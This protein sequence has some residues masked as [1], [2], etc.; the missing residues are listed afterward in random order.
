MP[1]QSIIGSAITASA[2]N[3]IQTLLG[4][5]GRSAIYL[6]NTILPNQTLDV[7][8]YI[9]L[10]RLRCLHPNHF[11]KEMLELG[12]DVSAIDAKEFKLCQRINADQIGIRDSTFQTA[13][14]PVEKSI[15][16]SKNLPSIDELIV[17][18]NR[19]QISY[20]LAYWMAK[21]QL[22]G[23]SELATEMLKLRYQIPG[24]SDLVSFAVRDCFTPEIVQ[25]FEYAK[26]LPTAILQYMEAQG[27]GGEIDMP[28]PPNATTT[29][30]PETRKKPKWFDMYWWS[31]W[32][33]PSLQQ[34]Y[35]M[36][37]RLYK[38]SKY[39]PSPEANADTYFTP[40][41]LEL[42]QKANDY[43]TFWRKRLQTISYNPLTR[44]DIRRMFEVGVLKE[45]ND[46]HEVFHAYKKLG[47]SDDDAQR[48]TDF[49]LRLSKKDIIHVSLKLADDLYV[50]GTIEKSEHQRYLNALGYSNDDVTAHVTALDLQMKHDEVKSQLL[51]IRKG[52]MEGNYTVDDLETV[53]R[54]IPIRE[55]A[56]KRYLRIWKLNRNARHKYVS[57]Q[58]ALTLYIKNI[59]TYDEAFNRLTN[60]GYL[61]AEINALFQE[62]QQDA[63]EKQAKQQAALATK[64]AKAQEQAAKKAK[65]AIDDANK[66]AEKRKQAIAKALEKHTAKQ[67]A[68]YTDK[69][70]T[71]F[72][73]AGFLSDDDVA[74]ILYAKGW[75]D[76]AV[77]AYIQDLEESKTNGKAKTTTQSTTQEAQQPTS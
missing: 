4:G 20:K 42:L 58:K 48:L 43:P 30:G 8:D 24:P 9:N 77:N 66:M 27:L 49:T 13:F 11:Q 31:H 61:Q 73:D 72:F 71:A 53:M 41:N 67:L 62:A 60:L 17:L 63:N 55:E 70:I 28:M 12:F 76:I 18:L 3:Q 34:G 65:K 21:I 46:N 14:N 25:T 15:V 7:T 45:D 64:L 54:K 5:I 16:L 68:A 57:A 44:V 74:A 59:V 2:Q 75:D 38:D 29:E 10:F 50:Q 36:L 32:Q 26:E 69:N 52:Y 22:G 19:G 37:H 47:Y 40:A 35:E 33:L 39:G 56:I 1:V 6:G 51:D 23:E